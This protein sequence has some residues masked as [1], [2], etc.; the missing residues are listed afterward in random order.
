MIGCGLVVVVG[1]LLRAKL[2]V[3]KKR[4]RDGVSSLVG[5]GYQKCCEFSGH[6]N[7]TDQ[8]LHVMKNQEQT[9]GGG[10]G[11]LWGGGG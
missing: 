9:G 7:E 3:S 11:F 5:L 6:K 10:G 1:V 4:K 2:G 8:S